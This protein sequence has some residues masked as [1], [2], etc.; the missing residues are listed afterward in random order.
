MHADQ[1]L[2]LGDDR[3][4]VVCYLDPSLKVLFIRVTGLNA[5]ACLHHHL[6]ALGDPF[7]L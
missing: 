7:F 2:C 1:P 6:C 4:A 5:S 3:R